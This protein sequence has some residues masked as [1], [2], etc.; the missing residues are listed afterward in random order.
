VYCKDDYRGRRHE[1]AK[2]VKLVD[3][4][5]LNLKLLVAIK[6]C[7]IFDKVMIRCWNESKSVD[8]KADEAYVRQKKQIGCPKTNQV[9]LMYGACHLAR[10]IGEMYLER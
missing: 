6:I 2:K 4:S 10:I 8:V 1:S 9:V 3:L 7:Y 5:S